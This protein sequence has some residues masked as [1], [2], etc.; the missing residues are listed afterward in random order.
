MTEYI[1]ISH[2]QKNPISRTPGELWGVC[3]EDL[4]GN[5]PRYSDVLK[6]YDNNWIQ[7]YI[8]EVC[9][10]EAIYFVISDDQRLTLYLNRYKRLAPSLTV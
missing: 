10:Y 1:Q 4:Q 2:S 9:L 7:R 6:S 5:W 3:C 8:S